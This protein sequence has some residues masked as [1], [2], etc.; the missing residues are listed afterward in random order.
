MSW[1]FCFFHRS[2]QKRLVHVSALRILNP[3]HEPRKKEVTYWFVGPEESRSLNSVSVLFI[4]IYILIY[5]MISLTTFHFI[6]K[7]HTHLSYTFLMS[8]NKK[9]HLNKGLCALK[10]TTPVV[11]PQGRWPAAS[12]AVQSL[13]WYWAERWGGFLPTPRVFGARKKGGVQNPQVLRFWAMFGKQIQNLV[14]TFCCFFPGNF[15][16]TI[17]IP[18]QNGGLVGFV[19]LF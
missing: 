8:S 3:F 10:N 1:C 18:D 15:I 6:I 12:L 5:L 16:G 13:Q 17:E 19:S 11:V 2:F 14:A 7:I 4:H 9:I